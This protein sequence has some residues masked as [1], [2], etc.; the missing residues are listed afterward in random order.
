M[1]SE[2]RV[3]LHSISLQVSFDFTIFQC[4]LKSF[5]KLRKT[6][7][8]DKYMVLITVV[9]SLDKKVY[10]NQQSDIYTVKIYSTTGR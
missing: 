8:W 10:A 9:F 2:T 3:I 6:A 7:K 5:K 1:G 4:F